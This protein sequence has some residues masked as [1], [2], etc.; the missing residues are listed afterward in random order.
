MMAKTDEELD[1]VQRLAQKH[2]IQLR[3]ICPSHSG[4]RSNPSR[5]THA[6]PVEAI[7]GDRRAIQAGGDVPA[8]VSVRRRVCH[9]VD[10]I[11]ALLPPLARA[12]LWPC[13]ET[14][15]PSIT[16]SPRR[17]PTTF[18]TRLCNTCARSAA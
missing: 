2:N 18:T 13:A 8:K 7:G 14:S 17:R 11:P 15:D 10:N 9:A 1:V 12:T 16:T 6:P 4:T 5:F 3:L